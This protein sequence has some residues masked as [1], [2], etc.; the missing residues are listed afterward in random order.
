MAGIGFRLEKILAKNSYFNLIEGY[1][2]SSIVSA[3]PLLCTIFTIALLTIIMPGNMDM[4]EIMIFRTLIVYIYGFSLIST[5]S[6]Q[7]ILTRYMADRIFMN[8][9]KAIVPAF[10]G[11]VSMSLVIHAVIG[12]IAASRLHLGIATEVTAVVLFLNIGI[13]WI[14]MIVLSAAKEFQWIVKSFAIGSLLSVIAGYLLGNYYGLFGLLTGFTLG[15]VLLVTLL[16]VQIFTEFDYRRRVEFY[17]LNYFKKFTALAFIATLYNIGI[18][19]DKIVFWASPVTH[20]NIHSFLYASSIYDVPVFIAYLLIVPSLA[21]FTIRVETSFYIHY[22][23]F[24]LSILNKHPYY[25]LEER[26]QNI[27]NSLK[28]AMG[29]MIVLQGTVTLVGLIAA[30][31][32]YPYLHMSSMQLGIF[33]IAMVATFLQALLQTLLIIMLYFD[34][35]MDALIMAAIFGI[36]NPLFSLISIKLGFGFYGYGYFASCLVALIIG[37]VLFDYKMRHLLYYTFVS[38]KIIVSKEAAPS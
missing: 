2:Y 29:R 10:V 7:M 1:A 13:I 24:F 19:G 34:F 27:V 5:S 38:Q 26:R 20:E 15:Q 37:F 32:V 4:H 33:Q 28:L 14:A 25:A 21:M 8:D 9:Y 17:F 30:P 3:G 16:I 31:K 18:W 6:V 12:F 22:K 11:I 35:R 23:K 36:S